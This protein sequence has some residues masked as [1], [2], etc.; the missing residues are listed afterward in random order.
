MLFLRES[1]HGIEHKHTSTRVAHKGIDGC[2][3]KDERLSRTGPGRDGGI[4]ALMHFAQGDVLMLVDA[5]RIR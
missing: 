4:F 5:A 2:D 3:L 1:A